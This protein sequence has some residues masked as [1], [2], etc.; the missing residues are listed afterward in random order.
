MTD[1]AGRLDVLAAEFAATPHLAS[2]G[3]ACPNNLLRR[4]G[5]PG[6]TLIDFAFWRPQPV[7]FDLSQLL[8]GDIQIGRQDVGD[9]PGRAEACVR[10]TPPGCATRGSTCPDQVGAATRSA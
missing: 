1:V 6:F 4:A 7:A 10:R 5:D 9:L 8:V 2:H 3:D